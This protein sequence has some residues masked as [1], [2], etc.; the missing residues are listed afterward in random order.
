MH[1]TTEI[2]C[3]NILG[4]GN[5]HFFTL[6][7]FHL[8]VRST[9]SQNTHNTVNQKHSKPNLR[10]FPHLDERAKAETNKLV[11]TFNPVEISRYSAFIIYYLLCVI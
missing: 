9:L 1:E 3:N 11:T 6:F 10:T 8:L 7:E 4:H 5:K 2:N